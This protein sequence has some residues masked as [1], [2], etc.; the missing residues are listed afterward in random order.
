MGDVINLRQARKA[1]A[2]DDKAQQAEANRAKFGRTKAQRRAE[3]TQRARQ[4]AAVDAA[5]R[6]DRA[7]E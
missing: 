1:K 5:Y 6:E 3:D 7:P 2:R 4:E